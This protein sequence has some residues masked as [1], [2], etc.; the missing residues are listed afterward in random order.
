ML[1]FLIL[2]YYQRNNAGEQ[3]LVRTPYG[4]LWQCSKHTLPFMLDVKMATDP[5][6]PLINSLVSTHT[7]KHDQT[8][9]YTHKMSSL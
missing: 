8:Q 3:D 4:M 9:L 6:S 2:L 7:S 5:C 1:L